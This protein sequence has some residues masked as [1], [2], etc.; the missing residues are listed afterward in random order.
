VHSTSAAAPMLMPTMTPV[1][2]PLDS[3][4]AG[5]GD[6]ESDSP[7]DPVSAGTG[8]GETVPLVGGGV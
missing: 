8:D 4:A 6:C 3:V 7:L 5:L 2:R 1:D